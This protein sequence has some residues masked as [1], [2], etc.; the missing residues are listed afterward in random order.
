MKAYYINLESAVARRIGLEDVFTKFA[1]SGW[2]LIRV[3]AI[4]KAEIRDRKV[5]GSITDSEKSCLLSHKRAIEASL[6]DNGH[7]LFLEDDASIGPRGFDALE[8]LRVLDQ[9]GI[10]M[11]FTS[12]LIANTELLLK[13]YLLYRTAIK[14][15]KTE[16]F[17]MKQLHFAGADGYI[18]NEKSKLKLIELLQATTSFDLPYDILLK[19]W[20][21]KGL[22]KAV[23]VFPFLTSLSADS[24]QSQLSN[25]NAD[26]NAFRRLLCIDSRFFREKLGEGGYNSLSGIESFTDEYLR[27]LKV[28]LIKYLDY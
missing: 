18:L 12:C 21:Q 23:V 13:Q 17:D 27:L 3:P 7:T 25:E 22:L 5:P 6:N 14:H 16:L 4:P 19:E 28:L 9:T 20:I 8:K 26:W 2:A 24:D 10:D 1:P 15:G 11:V